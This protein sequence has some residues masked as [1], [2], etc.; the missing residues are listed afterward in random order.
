MATASIIQKRIDVAYF[1]SHFPIEDHHMGEFAVGYLVLQRE[2]I[3]PALEQ[4]LIKG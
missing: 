4:R 1:S 2:Q 3:V